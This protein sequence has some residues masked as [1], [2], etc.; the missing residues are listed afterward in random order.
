MFCAFFSA[1]LVV[2]VLLNRSLFCWWR[3]MILSSIVSLHI[4]LT[5]STLFFYPILWTL[6]IA[7][8]ST[9]GFHQGSTKNAWLATVRLRPTPP[10][11]REIRKTFICLLNLNSSSTS[12]LFFWGIL[13]S[14]FYQVGFWVR[15]GRR[16]YGSSDWLLDNVHRWALTKYLILLSL[17]SCSRRDIMPMNYEKITHFSFFSTTSS[18]CLRMASILALL[19]YFFSISTLKRLSLQRQNIN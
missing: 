9:A 10:A 5:T 19:L 16:N 12:A 3:S 14:S 15:C 11:F 7:C 17:K 13:P 6:S 18:T 2:I 1:W 4:N 8:S